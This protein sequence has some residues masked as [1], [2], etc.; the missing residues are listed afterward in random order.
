MKKLLGEV[1]VDPTELSNWAKGM[2]KM[3]IRAIQNRGSKGRSDKRSSAIVPS[4]RVSS[5]LA[6]ENQ[7]KKAVPHNISLL[8]G[9]LL[10][11]LMDPS[12]N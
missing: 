10:S 2:G 6:V 3:I 4:S 5:V 11:R 1:T 8:K 12:S 7:S 9:N